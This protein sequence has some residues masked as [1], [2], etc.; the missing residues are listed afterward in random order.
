MAKVIPVLNSQGTMIWIADVP[1]AGFADCPAAI[2]AIKAGKLVGC[3]QS[4]GAIEETRAVTEYKCMSSNDTAKALG[5]ITRGN[6]E[7]GLLFDPKDTAGQKALKDAWLA[8]EEFIVGVE[9]P[10]ADTSTGSTGASGTIFWFAGSIS[11]VSTGIVQDEAVT[12][13]VT[14][15]IASNVTECPMVPGT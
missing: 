14:I 8:N 7:I 4:I 5:S 15:E 11:G 1:A 3:P 2:T 12:Y 6:I 13:T 9:L 10:D